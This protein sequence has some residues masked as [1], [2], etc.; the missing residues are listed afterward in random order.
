MCYEES[1]EAIVPV[2]TRRGRAELYV[3]EGSLHCAATE[4]QKIILRWIVLMRKAPDGIR[5][6]PDECSK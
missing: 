2:S 6:G 1:A 4:Q 3:E 5:E